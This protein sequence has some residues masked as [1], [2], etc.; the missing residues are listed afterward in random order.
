MD[1]TLTW[2]KIRRMLEEHSPSYSGFI[3]ATTMRPM[4]SVR[5]VT[6]MGMG[7]SDMIDLVVDRAPKEVLGILIESHGKD[8]YTHEDMHSKDCDG[9]LCPEHIRIVI[10]ELIGL[11]RQ[12]HG[13][14]WN[15]TS[16]LPLTDSSSPLSRARLFLFPSRGSGRQV[17]R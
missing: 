5:P 17:R 8:S 4:A 11:R 14:M 10:S 13:L 7:V 12:G 15:R 16:V 6:R 9:S 1:S 3:R 2:S